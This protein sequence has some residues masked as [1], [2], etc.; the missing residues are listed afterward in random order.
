M[1]H[2]RHRVCLLWTHHLHHQCHLWMILVKHK[3]NQD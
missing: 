2:L 3:M 1:H